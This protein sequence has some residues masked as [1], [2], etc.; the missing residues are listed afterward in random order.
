MLPGPI[1]AI[2]L[3]HCIAR[4]KKD[5]GEYDVTNPSLLA[6][7]LGVARPRVRENIYA[8]SAFCYIYHWVDAGAMDGIPQPDEF[9]LVT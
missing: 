5:L 6:I 4:A 7:G 9:T 3:E 2:A 8:Y 1:A